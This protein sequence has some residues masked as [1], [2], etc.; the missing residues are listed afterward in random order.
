MIIIIAR[1]I[2][3]LETFFQKLNKLVLNSKSLALIFDIVSL[4]WIMV[5]DSEKVTTMRTPFLDVENMT[6]IIR[7]LKL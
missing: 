4:V 5:Y 1:N 7:R 3:Y 6:I 2:L